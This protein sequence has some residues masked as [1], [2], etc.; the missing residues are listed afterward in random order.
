M[1]PKQE[2]QTDNSIINIL[3]ELTDLKSESN[4]FDCGGTEVEK[5]LFQRID[6][7]EKYFNQKL[8]F[9]EIR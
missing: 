7:V 3:G 2:E 9:I 1:E 8:K 6:F 4:Y 5:L